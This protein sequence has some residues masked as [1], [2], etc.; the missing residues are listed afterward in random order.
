MKAPTE[1]EM[2]RADL[3]IADAK[4]TLA[5]TML[6]FLVGELHGVGLTSVTVSKLA[7]LDYIAE[8]EGSDPAL[9]IAAL[10]LRT[11]DPDASAADILTAN[12]PEFER[13]YRNLL[14]HIRRDHP[15]GSRREK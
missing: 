10:E 2:L 7:S 15:T 9:A 14:A 1:T 11:T 8:N 3:E 12:R 6:R 4:A 13:H 5:L